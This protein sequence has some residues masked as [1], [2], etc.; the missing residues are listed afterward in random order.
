MKK[1]INKNN[2]QELK[3]LLNS[4]IKEAEK[5]LELWYDF[6]TSQRALKFFLE[7]IKIFE[8]KQLNTDSKKVKKIQEL[9]SKT[10]KGFEFDNK[11]YES[12]LKEL[13]CIN[14]KATGK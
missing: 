7:T 2:K 9:L 8:N 11:K 6:S 13:N 12:E 3:K 1:K 4:K 10:S 14:K 5:E